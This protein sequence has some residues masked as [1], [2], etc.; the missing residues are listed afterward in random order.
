M[1]GAEEVDSAGE[2]SA[3]SS[4]EWE[5]GF[6]VLKDL[7]ASHG[8]CVST[9]LLGQEL[10]EELD[11]A[12]AQ[13]LVVGLKLFKPETDSESGIPTAGFGYHHLGRSFYSEEKYAEVL[14]REDTAAA[15]AEHA[16][17]ARQAALLGR[18][19]APHIHRKQEERRLV[20]YVQT[21]LVGL[22]DSEA[23][24]EA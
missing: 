1:D 7:L 16:S 15:E 8:G 9:K 22:Y 20:A 19:D 18:P 6:S 14:K 4:Q 24:P 5:H 13:S 3:P 17:L 11:T 12:R 21:A 2:S 23:A 10:K